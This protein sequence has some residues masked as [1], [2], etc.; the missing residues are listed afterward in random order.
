MAQTTV[1]LC[2]G[3]YIGIETIFT[4][5][6]GK[7]INIPEKIKWFRKKSR[8][9]EL[10]C[11]CGCGANVILVAG[12]RNIREQHFRMKHGTYEDK[13]H[14]GVE[15]KTYGDSMTVL[16]CWLVDKLETTDVETRVPISLVD[17]TERNYEFSLLSRSKKLAVSYCRDRANL[18]DEKLEILKSNSKDIHLVYVADIMNG[19]NNGQ[20]PEA[21]MKIQDRQGYCLL[22]NIEDRLY[23]KAA[24][25]AVSYIQDIDGLWKEVCISEGRLSDYT[26]AEDGQILYKNELLLTL[27]DKQIAKLKK[28]M[29]EEKER[30]DKERKRREDEIKRIQAETEMRQ[31]EL[32]KEQEKCKKEREQRQ[33]EIR[34]QREKEEAERQAEIKRRDEEFKRN[35]EAD[36]LQQKTP[37]IDVEGNR[38]IKCEFCGLIAKESEFSSYGGYNHVNLGTCRACSSKGADKK[39]MFVTKSETE[40]NNIR[41]RYDVSI[42]PNCGGKLKRKNG[43]YGVFFGCS[44]YPQCRYTR[45]VKK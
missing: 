23:N 15:T 16:K 44:N 38:W 7:Q 28:A 19:G 2:D 41:V 11:A 26:I 25:C 12:D 37:I 20:Y 45:K 32:Q 3:K 35:I 9:N 14:I 13:G 22:L 40:S 6:N 36:L 27:V 18:S 34:K 30:R 42:C 43:L 31:L 29:Q 21:L 39:A 24:M 4:V 1:C 17:D 8:N 10:F 5:A 33:E